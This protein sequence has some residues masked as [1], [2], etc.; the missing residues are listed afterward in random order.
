[1]EQWISAWLTWLEHEKGRE[2]TTRKLYERTVTR[3]AKDMSDVGPLE[4]LTTTDLLAWLH[5]QGGSPASYGNRVAALRSFYG[6]LAERKLILDDPTRRIEIPK[7][8]WT[9]REPVR[10]LEAKLSAL[11]DLDR[12]RDRR[13]G[14]SR[15]MAV[16][17][18]ETGMRVSDAC[19]I[20]VIPPSPSSI[21][22]SRGRKLDRVINLS[23]RAR[24]ALDNLEGRFGIGPRA[25]QRR[26]E[27]VGFHPEQ[28]RHWHRV[29]LAD[30]HLRD[31]TDSL[32]VSRPELHTSEPA[33]VGSEETAVHKNPLREPLSAV[34]RFLS[35]AEDV[36]SVLVSE[37]RRQGVDW[38]EIAAALSISA[39]D[40]RQRFASS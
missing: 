25:L 5:E 12:A 21:R 7:R 18:A 22:I 24:T 34:G 27:K 33:D 28:L 16:F 40:A 23:P 8:V 20:S 29:N 19:R 6:Y 14:E 26:F 38:D 30:R 10:D 2:P 4:S 31:E 35:L 11:D 3:F 15:D 36:V 1:M 9:P 17:L 32:P 13:V 39:T 37:A